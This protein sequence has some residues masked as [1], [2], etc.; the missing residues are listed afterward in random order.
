MQRLTGESMDALTT[1]ALITAGFSFLSTVGL[2][3]LQLRTQKSQA[4]KTDVEAYTEL[5]KTATEKT[6]TDLSILRS[7]N[8]QLNIHVTH[9]QERITVLENEKTHYLDYIA[10]IEARLE[11]CE[12]KLPK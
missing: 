10:E 9:L 4:K 2:G 7:I 5:I 11:N 3:L 6:E 12:R 8:E 1:V